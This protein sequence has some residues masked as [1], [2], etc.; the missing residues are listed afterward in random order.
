MD[1]ALSE[2]EIHQVLTSEIFGHLACCDSGKPYVV[3][4]AFVFHGNALYGQ[5]TEGKKIEILRKNPLVC[6]QVQQR[7]QREWR[8]VL[9]WGTFE[10]FDF[11]KLGDKES[12]VIVGLLTKRLGDIQ[13][14]VGITLPRYSFNGEA[15]ALLVNDRRSTLFRIVVTEKTGR[16]F[17]AT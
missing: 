11:E 17:M 7:K 12:M 9:C 15:K 16:C 1:R 5:T 10:E 8:S 14:D 4:L 2:P 3:P 13:K 6:F